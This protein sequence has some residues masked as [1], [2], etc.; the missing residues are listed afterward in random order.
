MARALDPNQ[1]T[2]PNCM[3]V[4]LHWTSGLTSTTSFSNVLHGNF[5]GTSPTDGT[6][7]TTLFSGFKSALTSSGFSADLS[8]QTHLTGV[9]I[10]DLRQANLPVF[11]ST[12]VA[13]AGTGAGTPVSVSTSIVVSLHTA[14]SGREWRGR[15][16]LGGLDSI[17]LADAHTH[18]A[19]AGNN[20]VAFMTAVDAAMSAAGLP[21]CI[22]QRGLLA[23]FTAANKPLPARAANTVD[24]T[25]WV[26]TNPR[27]D[28]Q[29]K[30]LGH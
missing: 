11:L 14:K 18:T 29:R 1:P 7:A 20:A 17:A 6:I 9:S 4:T 25:A 19:T 28:T 22:A 3:Q 21:M 12:G 16:Y 27:L 26:I 23:G 30:R 5:T 13:A 24:V 15:T 8:T 10:K 2:I